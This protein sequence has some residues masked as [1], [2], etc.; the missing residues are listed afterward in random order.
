MGSPGSREPSVNFY[1]KDTY[2]NKDELWLGIFSGGRVSNLLNFKWLKGYGPVQLLFGRDMTFPINQQKQMQI[3]KY[4]IRKNN[5][6]VDHDYK[7]RDKVVLN[8]YAA[9]KY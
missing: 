2:V 7:V 3:N 4:Y 1:I 5:K 8:I 9:Y 6:G